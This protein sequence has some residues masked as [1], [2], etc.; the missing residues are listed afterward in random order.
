MKVGVAISGDYASQVSNMQF[1]FFLPWQQTYRFRPSWIG[2]LVTACCIALFVKLG[3]WQYEKAEKKRQL[4]SVYDSY[5]QHEPVNLPEA[6]PD[7]E[8]WR[9]RPVKVNGE[10]VTQYQLLLDNQIEDG[11]AG[12]HVITP[13]RI[14]NS[15]RLVLVDR[16]WVPASASHTDLPAIETPQGPQEIIGQGW[17]PPDKFYSLGEESADVKQ[18]WQVLW[19]NMDMKRYQKLVRLEVLPV[20]IRLDPASNAGGFVRNWVRPDDRITTHIGY[21]YQWFGFAVAAF[22]IFIAASFRKNLT[23]Q[24]K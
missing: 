18:P 21:A 4:Q 13:L 19:Q 12:Y 3:F 23:S 10:Y 5:L 1:P 9:Y 8:A 14:G 16:G 22:L 6:F 20:V 2:L 7:R 17:I 24:N 15:Q 11:R